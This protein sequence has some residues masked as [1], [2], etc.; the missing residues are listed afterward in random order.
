MLRKFV[1]AC[2]TFCLDFPYT[3]YYKTLQYLIKLVCL[4]GISVI[5][6]GFCANQLTDYSYIIDN[7]FFIDQSGA[8]LRCASGL[9]PSDEQSSSSLGGWYFKGTKID[10][11]DVCGS[12][13]QM[14]SLGR[15]Y[16]GVINL[17]PCGSLSPDK[18]GIYSCV[19]KNSSMMVQTIRVG[20][21]LKGRSMSWNINP[22]ILLLHSFTQLFQ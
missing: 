10:S 7:K 9:G 21:Y 2:L 3:F 17:Y 16:P 12:G 13:F 5:T 8:L 6:T 20:L 14:R 22:N 11:G 19:M 1:F 15:R 4:L 18:E